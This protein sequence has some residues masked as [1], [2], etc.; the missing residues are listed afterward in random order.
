MPKIIVTMTSWKQRIN[1]VSWVI[2]QFLSK[3]TIKPDVFYLWLSKEEF[4]NGPSDLPVDLQKLS[5]LIQ[6]QFLDG[7]DYCFKRWNVYPRHYEDYVISIDDDSYH[8]SHLIEDGLNTLRCHQSALCICN[9]WRQ[10]SAVP[11]YVNDIKLKFNYV[12][13]KISRQIWPCATCII[14]PKTFPLESLADD[15]TNFRRKFL[16]YNDEAWLIPFYLKND[17]YVTYIDRLTHYQTIRN[18]IATSLHNNNNN[19]KDTFGYSVTEK[20]LYFMLRKT[21]MIEKYKQIFPGYDPA[22]F[23]KSYAHM[24]EQIF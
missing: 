15:V 19:N 6:I 3:Q 11:F 14:P 2:L 17:V 16:P 10:F 8:S 21:S 12:P 13:Q 9:V 20:S 4:P 23:E 1:T 18:E 5:T 24:L 7:N 22:M